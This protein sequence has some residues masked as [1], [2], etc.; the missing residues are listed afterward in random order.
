MQKPRATILLLR[1]AAPVYNDDKCVL[2][3]VRGFIL[4]FTRRKGRN[5]GLEAA[6]YIAQASTKNPFV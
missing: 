5:L 2:P 6:E 3:P 4:F 1:V